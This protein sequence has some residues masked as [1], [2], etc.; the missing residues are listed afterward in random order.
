MTIK[1]LIIDPDIAFTV[2]IKRALEQSGDYVVNVFANGRA[3]IEAVQREAQD[4]AI[5]DFNIDDMS[6]PEVIQGL[7]QVQPGLF[8]LTSPRSVDDVG[9][10]PTLDAQ[11]SITKPYFA[12]QLGP[13]IR[14]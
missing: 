3:A 13:V 8:I 4:V 6:L 5:L 2:P 7:R 11:G 14:E 9:K 1:V 12:R 10:L